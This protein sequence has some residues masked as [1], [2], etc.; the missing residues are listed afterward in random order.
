MPEATLVQWLM[1]Q[2]PIIVVLGAV[3]WWMK[4]KYE[5]AVKKIDTVNEEKANLAR[6]V[7]KITVLWEQKHNLDNEVNA[8]IKRLLLE[9]REAVS[10]KR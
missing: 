1:G 6:D 7:V 8:E 4:G 3:L 5:E 2:A 10:V 9:I